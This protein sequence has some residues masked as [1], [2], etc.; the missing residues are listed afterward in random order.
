MLSDVVQIFAR[1]DGL[2][3]AVD[4]GAG[5]VQTQNQFPGGY[6]VS[7]WIAAFTMFIFWLLSLVLCPLAATTG[8]RDK[9]AVVCCPIT[10]HASQF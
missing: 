8:S 10:S 6:T 2:E 5:G 3:S 9:F 4:P 1:A 7:V